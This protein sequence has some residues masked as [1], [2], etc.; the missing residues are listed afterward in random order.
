[1]YKTRSALSALNVNKSRRARNVHPMQNDAAETKNT[2]SLSEN[3]TD[4]TK[5]NRRLPSKAPPKRNETV[6]MNENAFE[7][8]PPSD[9]R[10]ISNGYD[11]LYLLD[12]N[13]ITSMSITAVRPNSDLISDSHCYFPI[14]YYDFILQGLNKRELSFADTIRPG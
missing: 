1:M 5:T 4:Y 10:R 11:D 9:S 12:I 14:Y 2:G 7:T 3:G 6:K 13:C 8:L